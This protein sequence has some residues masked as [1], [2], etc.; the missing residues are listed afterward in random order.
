MIIARDFY[1]HKLIRKKHNGLIKVITGM[2]RCGKSFL[3][4]KIFR[5]HLIAEGIDASHIIEMSFDA[6]EF[7]A[8]RDPHVFYPYVK[9]HIVDNKQYYIL[10]DEV[11]LL[12]DFESVL[13]SLIRLE[14]V[15]VYVT[16]SN[17]KLLSK[18]I[19]TEFRGRGDELRMQ[20][21]SFAEF[22]SVY[23]GSIEAGW[24]EYLVYGGLPL[25][26]SFENA[27]DKSEFLKQ[28]WAETY[29]SDLIARNKIR[30][31]EE[32]GELINI[33]ASAMG[34]LTNA[35]K[36][37][38]SFASMKQVALSPATIKHYIEHLEDAFLV[39]GA[40]R[41]DIKGKKYINTPLKYYF[42]DLGIRNARLNFRQLEGTHALENVIYNELLRRGYNVDVGVVVQYFI[43]E[44]GQQSRK[45]LEIDF[46]C[47]KQSSR[48]YIQSALTLPN[49]AKIEQE[50]RLLKLANDGFKK[51]IIT[52][53]VIA[54]YYTD[55]GILMLGLFDFLLNPNILER[56]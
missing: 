22:M 42:A 1:L 39:S 54:P 34:S 15:D 29:I 48:Y 28:L 49:E 35:N 21:L 30:N 37:A 40:F 16:G 33:L 20:P 56:S 53:D 23:P 44:Q 4:F 51:I 12:Q 24:K 5:E 45:Q 26:A 14:N 9:E 32:F 7:T 55:D 19:I 2:R 3:L 27:E 10:L 11:Q 36:L 31:E 43:D 13:N 50:Q 18:D 25:V 46:V 6:F 17:A 47:N 41:Y 8:Y 52:K 38:A